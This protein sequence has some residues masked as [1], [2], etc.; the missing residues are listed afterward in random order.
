MNNSLVQIE[1]SKREVL[2]KQVKSR[3]QAGFT[4]ANIV[5]KGKPS[6]AIEIPTPT[7]IK[8]L[9]QAGYTQALELLV[10]KKKL[11][12]LVTDVTFA[13]TGDEPEHVVF[14]EV[15]KGERVTAS[16]PL[17]VIGDAPGEKKGLLVLQT[18][19]QLE[20]SSFA[21]Q[22]PEQFEIDISHLEESGDTVR[23]EEIDLPEGVEVDLDLQTPIVKLEMSRSQV[24]QDAEEEEIAE[25][26]DQEAGEGTET[27]S[28]KDNS[29]ADSSEKDDKN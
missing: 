23:I 26:E 4:P 2:G 6:L 29:D 22:I 13:P 15:K 24:S 28:E 12:V 16:V 1:A 25:D 21:L 17:I 3:R 10:D 18:L 5:A 7:L 8:I 9:D 11:T 14:F 20:V 27:K 19:H